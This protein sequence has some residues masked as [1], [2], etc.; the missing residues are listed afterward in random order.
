MSVHENDDRPLW[1]QGIAGQGCPRDGS[2]AGD[3]GRACALALSGAGAQVIAVARTRSELDSLATEAP[4][5]VEAWVEDVIGDA[6]LARIEALDRLDVLVNNAGT[7]RPQPFLEVTDE[8]LDTM[9]DLNRPGCRS[10]SPAAQ[11]G[12]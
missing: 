3:L 4:G 1:A 9:L 10:A 5:P 8:V 7:N 11:R 2:G 6:L 12:S